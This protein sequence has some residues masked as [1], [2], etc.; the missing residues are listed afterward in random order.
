MSRNEG[1]LFVRNLKPGLYSFN[2]ERYGSVKLALEESDG[3]LKSTIRLDGARPVLNRNG[4][5]VLKSTITKHSGGVDFDAAWRGLSEADRSLIGNFA[6]ERELPH[7]EIVNV[8]DNRASIPLHVRRKMG[9]TGE[10]PAGNRFLKAD[11]F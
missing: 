1:E 9:R 6:V 4:E 11:A 10:I 2:H 7:G 3:Y 8:V 5:P